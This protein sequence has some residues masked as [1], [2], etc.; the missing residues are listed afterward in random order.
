MSALGLA[1]E[2]RFRVFR[3]YDHSTLV[4]TADLLAHLRLHPGWRTV[5]D[6]AAAL[7]DM[8]A[9]GMDRVVPLEEK[10]DTAVAR[11]RAAAAAMG[12]VVPM[13]GQRVWTG[14]KCVGCSSYL[15]RQRAAGAATVLPS[16]FANYMYAHRK[17]F[18]A[19]HTTAKCYASQQEQQHGGAAAPPDP[20]C[21]VAYYQ[22]L[23]QRVAQTLGNPCIEVRFVGV[24]CVVMGL[25]AL[26][27]GCLWGL[28]VDSC[29][30]RTPGS[31]VMLGPPPPPPGGGGGGGGGG[32]VVVVGGGGGGG[33]GVVEYFGD[34]S[35]ECS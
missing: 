22:E 2:L 9:L 30:T 16:G 15:D 33:G 28:G 13:P 26:C 17:T 10:T 35:C 18:K 34:G 12:P 3:C 11:V 24:G 25:G 20:Q 21:A 4:G 6:Q 27:V 29:M 5:G 31:R 7:A 1:I 19:G 23:T 8:L 32:G 14:V